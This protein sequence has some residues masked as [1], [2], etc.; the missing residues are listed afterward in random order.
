[1]ASRIGDPVGLDDAATLPLSRAGSTNCEKTRALND[2]AALSQSEL[3]RQ[4]AAKRLNNDPI[5]IVAFTAV[6][7]AVCKLDDSL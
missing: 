1:M 7:P 5:L 2:A 3:A 6:L 4:I